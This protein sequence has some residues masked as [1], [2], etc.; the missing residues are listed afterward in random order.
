MKVFKEKGKINTQE[1]L[2]IA[3]TAAKERGYDIISA[4]TGGDS[5]LAL[6]DMADEMDYKGKIIIV[7]H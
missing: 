2:R 1:T 7:T 5:A 6:L 4:T 3:V